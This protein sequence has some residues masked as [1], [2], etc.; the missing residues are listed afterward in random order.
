MK[1]KLQIKTQ[2][3]KIKRSKP[4]F[5][6][7]SV[8]LDGTL[9]SFSASNFPEAYQ[10]TVDMQKEAKEDTM[11]VLYERVE[12]KYSKLETWEIAYPNAEYANLPRSIKER[13]LSIYTKNI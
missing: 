7:I 10:M 11:I 4:N 2:A 9:E 3:K 1:I 5:I 8:C 12:G 13:Y 6:I